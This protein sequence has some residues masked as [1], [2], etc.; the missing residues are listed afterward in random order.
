MQAENTNPVAGTRIVLRACSGTNPPLDTQV[1]AYRSDLSIQLV[2]SVKPATP[3]GLCVD[4]QPTAHS[5]GPGVVLKACGV[6]N[7][8]KCADITRCSPWNQQWSI[9]DLA[10]FEGA[11]TDQSNTDGTCIHAAAQADGTPLTVQGCK[12]GTDDPNQT[13]VPSPNA[14]AGMAGPTNKQLVN[15]RQF[16]T[17]VDITGANIS[18]TYAILYTCK[19]NPDPSRVRW[20]QKFNPVPALTAAPTT[21][22]LIITGD[23][24][25][26]Y[27]LIS[28]RTPGGYARGSG[29]CPADASTPSSSSWTVYQTQDASGNDLP[30]A[31]KFT[32]VD[33]SGLCLAPGP[34]SDMLN[35]QYLKV[36]V[37]TCDGSTSQKWNAS[38]SLDRSRVIATHELQAP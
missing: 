5:T 26:R 24:G 13:W 7:P 18:A 3:A 23:F 35:N 29:G 22:Q 2:S 17:C 31:Q 36:I 14:G 20:N 28:A 9:N 1:F 19:Q 34:N 10:H 33:S 37:D 25:E 12:G 4:T 11:A 27:C 21:T 16:A 6:A 32:I 8:A 15:Y 30:Y 38:A